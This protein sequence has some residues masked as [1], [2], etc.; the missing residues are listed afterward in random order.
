MPLYPWSAMSQGMRVNSFSFRYLHLWTCGESIKELGVA[1]TTLW[2]EGHHRNSIWR[3]PQY[4][5]IVSINNNEVIVLSQMQGTNLGFKVLW[6]WAFMNLHEFL[7]N[8]SHVGSG[9][10]ETTF[11][12][13]IDNKH[14]FEPL[15]NLSIMKEWVLCF[16]I[17]TLNFRQTRK[18]NYTITILVVGWILRIRLILKEWNM[19]LHHNGEDWQAFSSGASRHICI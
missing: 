2:K 18:I 6:A 14:A 3:R 13:E 5:Q 15:K 17:G 19:S 4:F 16:Q 12:I 8:F 11:S 7:F 9:F 1:S 10:F